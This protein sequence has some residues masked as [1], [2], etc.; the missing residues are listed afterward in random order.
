[1]HNSPDATLLRWVLATHKS[2]WVLKAW[3]VEETSTGLPST[4]GAMR[5]NKYV[6]GKW[7]RKRSKLG[8]VGGEEVSA[9]RSTL[10]LAA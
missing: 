5:R 1:M 9:E 8:R 4:S 2:I 7:E 6:L 3:A 10:M